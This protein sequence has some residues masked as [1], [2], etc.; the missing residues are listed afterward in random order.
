MNDVAAKRTRIAGEPVRHESAHLHVSG[1]AV[2]TDDIA[3]PENALHA[4]F[5][6]SRIAHGRV[7]SLALDAVRS[8]PGVVEIALA[9]DVPGENNYGSIL[10][11]DPIF[12]DGLVQ[13]AGQPLGE[14]LLLSQDADGR[15]AMLH[16]Q[17]VVVRLHQVLFLE[18]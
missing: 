3:L 9:A 13:Y 8:A 11:D 7:T 10:K 14:G 18:L 17:V 6:I 1:Q 2:Y 4:A 16:L 12:A 15:F 5:G